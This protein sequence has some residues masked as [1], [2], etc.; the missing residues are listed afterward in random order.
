MT[1]SDDTGSEELSTENAQ[2]DVKSMV[3]KLSKNDWEIP[4]G[5]IPNMRVPGRLF[6]SENLL[7]DLDRGTIDQIAN[8]A[9]LP[10]IQNYS[11]AM[12]DAHLGYGFAIGGVAA[13][14]VDE[15][16]ISPGGVGF[17]INCG[18][19]LVRTNLQKEDVLPHMK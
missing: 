12:P 5:H 1:E 13:F 14:D 15:G 17:D 4:I 10:G 19:R 2:A 18:V 3:R 7:E 8:V 16:V 11:M 9:T 6:I